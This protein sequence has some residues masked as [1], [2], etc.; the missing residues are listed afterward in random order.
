MKICVLNN[1]KQLV[2]IIGEQ[3][4][5][6]CVAKTTMCFA[7][8]ADVCVWLSFELAVLERPQLRCSM[9]EGFDEHSTLLWYA[10]SITV[11]LLA[12]YT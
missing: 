5:C 8:Q 11:V 2:C 10:W 3:V 12:L 7:S 6:C 9:W 1:V 4:L